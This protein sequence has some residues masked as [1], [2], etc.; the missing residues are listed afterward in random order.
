MTIYVIGPDSGPVKLGYTGANVKRRLTQ[1]AMGSSQALKLLWQTE[2]GQDLERRLHQRLIASRVRGEW[3][4]LGDSPVERV[5]EALR[6]EGV[7]TPAELEPRPT[8]LA[9]LLVDRSSDYPPRRRKLD[10]GDLCAWMDPDHPFHLVIETA[11]ESAEPAMVSL[12][13]GAGCQLQ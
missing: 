4:D 11:P 13:P 1:L 8:R 3:F 7:A 2:G 12:M 10:I 5:K 9:P 6:E